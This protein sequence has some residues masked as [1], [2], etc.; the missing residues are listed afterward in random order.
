MMKRKIKQLLCELAKYA[1]KQFK[2]MLCMAFGAALFLGSVQ[3]FQNW[4]KKPLERAPCLLIAI[5]LILV[6]VYIATRIDYGEDNK[7][8]P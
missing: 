3:L 6:I 5:I 1:W 2:N 7:D 8:S 4:Y